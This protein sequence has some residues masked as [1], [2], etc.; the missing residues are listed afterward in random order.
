MVYD[1]INNKGASIFNMSNQTSNLDDKG[2]E[3]SL[4]EWLVL[5]SWVGEEEKREMGIKA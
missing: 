2:K 3:Y 1:M 5:N 4:S